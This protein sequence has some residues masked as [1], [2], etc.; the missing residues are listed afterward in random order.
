MNKETNRKPLSRDELKSQLMEQIG[1][2]IASSKSFDEGKREE[3]KRLAAQL[4]I[5]CHDPQRKSRTKSLLKQL[6]LKTIKFRNSA[7]LFDSKSLV[8]YAGLVGI[9]FDG[10]SGR[11]AWFAPHG[12]PNS[13]PEPALVRFNKWWEMPVLR[14]RNVLFSRKDL[15]IHVAETDGGSH[16]DSSLDESYLALT[17]LNSIDVTTIQDNIEEPIGNPVL[18]CIRQ[19]AHEFL[20]SLYESSPELF[21]DSYSFEKIGSPPANN[22]GTG[23]PSVC[24]VKVGFL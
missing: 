22:P 11:R 2:L 18:P 10:P 3:A 23:I 21:P 8:P 14:V 5:L 4:R 17:R 6:G 12:N 24:V 13:W 16:V 19:I 9:K 7:P 15:V 20:I 1:F